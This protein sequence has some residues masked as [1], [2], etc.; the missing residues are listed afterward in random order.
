MNITHF[1]IYLFLYRDCHIRLKNNNS[2]IVAL[3]LYD[4]MCGCW[5]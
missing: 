3:L 5:K 1:E 4:L 2:I